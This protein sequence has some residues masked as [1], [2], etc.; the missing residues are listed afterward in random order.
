MTVQETTE[1]NLTNERFYRSEQYLLRNIGGINFLVPT[2]WHPPNKPNLIQINDTGK[3]IWCSIKNG[4]NLNSLVSRVSKKYSATPEK[5]RLDIIAFLDKL[6]TVGAIRFAKNSLNSD[7]AVPPDKHTK[8]N[9]DFLSTVIKTY[10]REIYLP[11]SITWE[12]THR[13]NLN[14]V[15]CYVSNKNNNRAKRDKE[16]DLHAIKDLIK[17]LE[18]NGCLQ[19]ILTGGELFTRNDILAILTV[20][21]TAGIFY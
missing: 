3:D 11:L 4:T 19:I 20:I 5:I 16:L 12:I 10:F 17:Q 13:C 21:K 7:G 6:K 8:N 15:H 18:A 1:N 9:E 14:C 2:I